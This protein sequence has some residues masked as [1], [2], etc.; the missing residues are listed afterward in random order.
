MNRFIFVLLFL[1]GCLF[2]NSVSASFL[3]IRAGYETQGINSIK[4]QDSNLPDQTSMAGF[5]GDIF[6]IPTDLVLGLRYENLSG[7]KESGSYSTEAKYT[8]TSAVIGYR[9]WNTGL[10][11][12][13]LLTV[14]MANLTYKTQSAS[15]A[16][17]K[18]DK[19][20]FGLGFE[21]GVHLVGL[22]V[23]A[24]VGFVSANLGNLKSGG[25]DAKG[26][27]GEVMT[28]DLS[29]TYARA[30]IGLSF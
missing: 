18:V 27:N 1:V 3:E 6:I 14:G 21:A 4:N 12:G 10:Y 20:S 24:E 26:A 15:S 19:T 16:E 7:K 30:V 13:P 5:T 22:L 25:S 2:A 9:I 23:G 17:S 29:G 8:R 28:A 11:L